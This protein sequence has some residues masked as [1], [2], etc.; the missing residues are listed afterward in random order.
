MHRSRRYT[1]LPEV[2]VTGSFIAMAASSIPPL[3]AQVPSENAG[4]RLD[5]V[6]AQ[7][8]PE[9]SRARLQEWIKQNALQLNDQPAKPRQKVRGGE[10]LSLT[11]ILVAQGQ[12]QAEDLPLDIVFEDE[13]ILVLNK[14]AN[15][16]VHPAAGNPSGTVLN[17]LLHHCQGFA[18][19]PRGGIVHRL[20]K[21]TTGLMVVAKTL[22]AHHHLVAQLQARTV[23]RHYLAIVNGLIPGA[24][25]VNAP[26]GRHPIQRKKMAAVKSGGKEAVTHYQVKQRFVRH[27]Y[28]GLTLETG[29]THQIRVHMQSI[30]HPLVGDPSYGGRPRVARQLGS[31]LNE[32]LQGFPRQ[33][34]HAGALQL[35]HPVTNELRSW[36]SALPTDMAQLLDALAHGAASRE[37]R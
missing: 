3:R 17:A 6:A 24:G 33:A 31:E 19:L 25:S 8:F 28:L 36:Q 34:L 26:I 29:R 7:L 4:D 12:W 2:M 5:Q 16:V 10:Q 13:H 9:F 20:D 14:A 37:D 35:I 21:D 18:N 32:L 15:T 11:P 30:G 1:L 23:G 27:S 22:Q